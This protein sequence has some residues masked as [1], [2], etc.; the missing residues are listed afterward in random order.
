[1][2]ISRQQTTVSVFFPVVIKISHHYKKQYNST[3]R[4]TDDCIFFF[5]G[6]NRQN[7]ALNRQM[8]VSFFFPVV[9]K[10]SR[11]YKKMLISR[12]NQKL[13]QQHNLPDRRLYLF[14]PVVI[15]RTAHPSDRRLYLFFS[16]RNVSFFSGRNRNFP[17][18]QKKLPISRQQTTVSFFSV[19]IKISC[20]YKKNANFPP[21]PKTDTTAQPARQTTVS[22]FFSGRNR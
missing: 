8:T 1:M 10:I 12:Q 9:I 15:A 19:V 17:P 14:F 22:L 20:H 21:E 13:I 11:H 7:R 16:G 3:T 6:R 5:S 4:Q 18:Q 2:P